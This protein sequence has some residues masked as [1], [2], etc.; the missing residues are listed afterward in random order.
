MVLDFA[1]EAIENVGTSFR[2]RLIELLKSFGYETWRIGTISIISLEEETQI[3]LNYDRPEEH[4]K[5]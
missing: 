4:E 3:Q 5:K 2:K 1:K